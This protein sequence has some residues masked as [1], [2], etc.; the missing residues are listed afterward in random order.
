MHPLFLSLLHLLPCVNLHRLYF[1]FYLLL[2]SGE[3]AFSLISPIP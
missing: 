3:L 1:S 2:H